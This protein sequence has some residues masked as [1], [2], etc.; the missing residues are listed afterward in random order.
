MI[1]NIAKS[2]KT[3]KSKRPKDEEYTKTKKGR[4]Q[5]PP[6]KNES[7]GKI[8]RTLTFHGKRLCKIV[9]RGRRFVHHLEICNGFESNFY[10]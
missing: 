4:K 1:Q 2:K 5:S 3:N 7:H 8:N 6:Q 10:S 9:F